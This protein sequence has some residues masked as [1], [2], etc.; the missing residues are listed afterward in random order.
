MQ[1]TSKPIHYAGLRLSFA[2]MMGL[3]IVPAYVVA[4]ILFAQLESMQAGLVAGKIFHVSNI[5]ILIL[6]VAAAW[7]CFRIKTSKTT[8]YLLGAVVLMVAINAFGVTVMMTAIK[9]EA[10]DI[11]ALDKDDTLRLAFAFWHGIG[12]IMQLISALFMVVLVMKKQQIVEVS[13]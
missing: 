11:S 3:L 6:A 4:P 5:A 12:S 8:W 9:S 7:F 10:G 13:A 2:L 1:M